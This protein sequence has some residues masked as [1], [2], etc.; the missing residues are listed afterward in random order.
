M[1]EIDLTKLAERVEDAPEPIKRV[2]SRDSKPNP[3]TPHVEAS[4]NARAERNGVMVG[5]T[6]QFRAYTAEQ[7][8]AIVRALRRASDKLNL[9][10]RIDA[11][12][13]EYQEDGKTKTRYK[14]GTVKFEAVVRQKRTRKE[15]GAQASTDAPEQEGSE[16]DGNESGD[17]DDTH[18]SDQEPSAED[19]GSATVYGDNPSHQEPAWQ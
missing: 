16:Q 18:E 1:A 9:G 8:T 6:K 17:E 11:P 7:T 12:E 14:A 10:V 4:W 5:A 19:D 15:N 13:E 3:F 2:V